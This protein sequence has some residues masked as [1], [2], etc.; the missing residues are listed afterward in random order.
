VV[1]GLAL[2][3]GDREKRGVCFCIYGYER[4]GWEWVKIDFSLRLLRGFCTGLWAYTLKFS[5]VS[6]C[7]KRHCADI[8]LPCQYLVGCE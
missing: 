7:V 1:Q 8:T 6:F 4:L 5:G 2:D 3:Q